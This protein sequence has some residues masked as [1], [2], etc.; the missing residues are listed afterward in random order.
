MQHKLLISTFLTALAASACGNDNGGTTVDAGGVPDAGGCNVEASFTS[1]HTN[2]LSTGLCATAGCHNEAAING[3]AGNLILSGAKDIAYNELTMESTFDPAAGVPSR[4]KAN[5][6]AMSYLLLK[7][8]PNPPSMLRMPQ[9]CDIGGVDRCRPECEIKA[10]E[11]W[12]NAG[13]MNN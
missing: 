4:V 11:D 13:A 3:V 5:E 9:G 10:V 8:K 2:L 6:A 1:I 7:L 12:I